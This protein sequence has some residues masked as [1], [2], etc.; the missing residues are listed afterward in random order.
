MIDAH[1][2]P[3]TAQHDSSERCSNPFCHAPMDAR[4]GKRFCS[5][6]CRMDSYVLRRAKAMIAEVG[7]VEFNRILKAL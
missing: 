4:H 3:L 6:R 7:I 5:D 2:E 1:S